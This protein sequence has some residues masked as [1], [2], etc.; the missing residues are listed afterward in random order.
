M[1]QA[2]LQVAIAATH[3]VM[4]NM[5]LQF[6]GDSMSECSLLLAICQ[7]TLFARRGCGRLVGRFRFAYEDGFDGSRTWLWGGGASMRDACRS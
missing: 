2:A 3:Q 4:E 6:G 7:R 5:I 1:T